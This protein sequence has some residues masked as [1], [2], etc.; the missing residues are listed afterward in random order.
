MILVYFVVIPNSKINAKQTITS[1]SFQLELELTLLC[2]G[3]TPD[4]AEVWEMEEVP[5]SC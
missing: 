1:T 4:H 3:K 5:L 2:K